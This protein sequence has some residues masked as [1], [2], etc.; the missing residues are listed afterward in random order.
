[1]NKNCGHWPL[2]EGEVGGGSLFGQMAY[3]SLVWLARLLLRLGPFVN[4]LYCPDNS[5]LSSQEYDLALGGKESQ[6]E[7]LV[8]VSSI[9]SVCG[10][11]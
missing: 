7:V 9:W 8:F 1:M 2:E 6:L 11:W 5:K 3:L 10:V 4:L